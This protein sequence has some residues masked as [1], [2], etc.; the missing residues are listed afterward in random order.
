M[1]KDYNIR[2]CPTI[3]LDQNKVQ[4]ALNWQG[5]ERQ[6]FEWMPMESSQ[7]TGCYVKMIKDFDLL[8]YDI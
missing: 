2:S 8:T 7:Y 1:I 6:F 5:D 4:T 3:K